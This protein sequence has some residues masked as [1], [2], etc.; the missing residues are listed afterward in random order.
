MITIV[1]I[2]FLEV[3]GC[4]VIPAQGELSLAQYSVLQSRCIR[5][6]PP[7]ASLGSGNFPV[8]L[9][10]AL[11]LVRRCRYS[12][13]Q[14]PCPKQIQNN[15]GHIGFFQ[16]C[17]HPFPALRPW[18]YPGFSAHNSGAITGEVFSLTGLGSSSHSNPPLAG[19]PRQRNNQKSS[20]TS[21][22]SSASLPSWSL[23]V[24]MLHSAF[25]GS[26]NLC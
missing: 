8:S 16:S 21:A 18:T 10:S 4:V 15:T 9:F 12:L 11:L 22:H 2:C 5:L 17:N 13:E 24:F 19:L 26:P 23:V 3:S 6:Q 14:F 25:P 20:C 7:L 1:F